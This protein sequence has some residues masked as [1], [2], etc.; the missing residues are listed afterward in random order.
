[1]PRTPMTPSAIEHLHFCRLAEAEEEHSK[2]VLWPFKLEPREQ[3]HNVQ[4]LS[5]TSEDDFKV[6]QLRSPYI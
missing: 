3:T 4:Y 1:M 5:A 6:S 2:D